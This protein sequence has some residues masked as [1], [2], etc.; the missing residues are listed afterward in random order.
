MDGDLD[1]SNFKFSSSDDG[2]YRRQPKMKKIQKSLKLF[3]RAWEK[4]EKW[5]RNKKIYS[6]F[7][8]GNQL[9]PE[10]ISELR[11]RSQPD[12]VI[13]KI[14]PQIDLVSGLRERF[15]QRI[16]AFNRNESEND[17][18]A[19]EGISEALRFIDQLNKIEFTDSEVFDDG[20]IDGRGWFHPMVE[21]DDELEPEV[22]IVYVPNNDIVVDP[23]AKEYDLQDGKNLWHTL[24]YDEED[25]IALFPNKER[26][27]RRAAASFIRSE[28]MS[29]IYTKKYA[30]DDYLAK[31][32]TEDD[33]RNLYYDRGQSRLRVIN[34]WY[35]VREKRT[36]LLH[37]ELGVGMIGAGVSQ[38]IID[39]SARDIAEQ[40]GIPPEFMD[41]VM[42][43]VKVC[44]L[45]GGEELEEKDSPFHHQKFPFIPYTVFKDRETKEPYGLIK[46]AIDPQ[47][48]VNKRRSKGLHILNTQTIIA[49]DGAVDD[50]EKA[51]V[52]VS[53]PD[54]YIKTNRGFKFEIQRNTELGNAQLQ[55]YEASIREID[56]ATGINRDLAGF[57]TN[58]RSGTALDKRIEQGLAVLSKVFTNWKRTKLLLAE[59]ILSLIQQYWTDEKAIRVTDD[60]N[61]VKFLRLNQT[62]MVGGK[63]V[64]MRNISTGKYDL[65]F[66]ES[67]TTLNLGEDVFRELAKM[68]QTGAIPPDIVMEFAP[69][70]Y[71]VKQRI[72]NILRPQP[73]QGAGEAPVDASQPPPGQ[74]GEIPP[75]LLAQ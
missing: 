4:S 49:E 74:N 31:L 44:T 8:D 34:H 41:R 42:P 9:T 11:S 7:Y 65:V 38:K 29:S 67:D 14:K 12:V 54:G 50:E 6:N 26:I 66:D 19:S 5:R 55:M 57:A 62:V 39:Q 18:L 48:E 68:A 40:T 28:N 1:L 53:R 15:K 36:M 33:V 58:A 61:V 32:Y 59:Q 71:Q 2:S 46:Q 16:K 75:E 22:K 27:I 51:R 20:I 60:Q 73:Q 21:L 69:V 72:L 43:I 13:N 70:P 64:V 23:D 24:W 17:Y 37:P 47:R 45:I 3:H 63:P 10:E 30:G 56:E 25:L 35:K 52:E